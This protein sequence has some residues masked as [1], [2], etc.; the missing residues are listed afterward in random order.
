VCRHFHLQRR[1]LPRA[2]L[3]V[4]L[5]SGRYRLHCS[6]R[7]GAQCAVCAP[8]CVPAAQQHRLRLLDSSA[9]ISHFFPWIAAVRTGRSMLLPA[10]RVPLEDDPCS[11]MSHIAYCK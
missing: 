7:C 11:T 5:A 4:L 6:S 2:L 9:E 1:R 3:V 8:L 10:V